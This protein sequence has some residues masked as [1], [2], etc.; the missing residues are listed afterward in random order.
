M[1]AQ[2]DPVAEA[3]ETARHGTL[4]GLLAFHLGRV[5]ARMWRS[6]AVLMARW[7]LK[8]G[9]FTALALISAN[10]GISQSEVA[11]ESGIDAPAVVA[12]MDDLERRGW[13]MR[14]RSTRDRRRQTLH[15]T[16]AGEAVL[17]ELITAARAN[18]A[19]LA[20]AVSAEEWRSLFSVLDRMY[21]RLGAGERAE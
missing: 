12:I 11:R 6:H 10:P 15:A 16:P 2:D 21:D 20:A 1:T 9:S 13:A 19:P 3:D 14:Q 17:V 18:E 7:D 5:W 4:E 8:P